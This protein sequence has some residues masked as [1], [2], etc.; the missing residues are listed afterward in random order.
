MD[1]RSRTG[2]ARS[3]LMIDGL[4]LFFRLNTL[5][6]YSSVK[7]L[8]YCTLSLG[9]LLELKY[10]QL[11]AHDGFGIPVRCWG[12]SVVVLFIFSDGELLAARIAFHDM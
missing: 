7:G 12:S 9:I 6:R 8:G 11:R 1:V 5:W 4:V 10:R 2:L 3:V